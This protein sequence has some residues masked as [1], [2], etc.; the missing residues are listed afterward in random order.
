MSASE[1]I[2]SMR[3]NAAQWKAFVGG[4][5]DFCSAEGVYWIASEIL[6]GAHLCDVEM[7]LI[8]KKNRI[9]ACHERDRK[10][11]WQPVA[12]AYPPASR[13][14]DEQLYAR[15]WRA[16]STVRSIGGRSS[17]PLIVL[18]GGTDLSAFLGMLE[19]LAERG[20]GRAA[21]AALLRRHECARSVRSRAARSL[22][23]AYRTLFV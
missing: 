9:D 12:V 22:R 13:W 7:E 20:G 16:R 3:R 1:S 5:I 14:R 17:A 8:F 4:C 23:G 18:A 11:G 19:E 6:T 2:V 10:S 15:A 21:C